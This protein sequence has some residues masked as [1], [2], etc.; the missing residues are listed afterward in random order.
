MKVIISS[1]GAVGGPKTRQ[2]GVDG[3]E[4]TPTPAGDFVIAGCR[5][6]ESRR[7][8]GGSSIPWGAPLKEESGVVMVKVDG[9]W[10][11]VTKFVGVTKED[12]IQAY[13]ALFAG[14]GLPKTWV[15]NSF[16]SN[17][18]YFFADTNKNGRLDGKE[19]VRNEFFH[20][21][22][23]NES[24]TALG[25]EVELEVSHGCIHLK[26]ADMLEMVRRGYLK[27]G[28]RLTIHPYSVETIPF[29]RRE[30]GKPPYHVHVF[31]GAFKVVVVGELKF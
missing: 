15:F 8:P 2:M 13:E 12:L 22:L 9:S 29:P 10:Q 6:H 16:G 20:T 25:Q 19:K 21:T 26:P 14:M 27:R 11:P 28:T 5:P 23:P 18:C 1:Y 3:F 7:Y 4:M 31:P 24:A 17:A 30:G